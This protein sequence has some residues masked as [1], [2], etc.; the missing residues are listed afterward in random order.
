FLIEV[1]L[2]LQINTVSFSIGDW[3]AKTLKATCTLIRILHF[4]EY[5]CFLVVT[6]FG[7]PLGLP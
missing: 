2:K 7:S 5:L 1:F 3:L 4:E 6:L